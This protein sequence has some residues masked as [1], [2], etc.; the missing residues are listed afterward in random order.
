MDR[1][2]LLAKAAAARAARAESSKV[3]AGSRAVAVIVYRFVR[4]ASARSRLSK[5]K[6]SG[7]AAK[8][9][10]LGKVAALLQVKGLPFVPPPPA[11][12]LLLRDLAQ[13]DVALP[14]DFASGAGSLFCQLVSWMRRS[15]LTGTALLQAKGGEGVLLRLLTRIM[16]RALLHPALPATDKLAFIDV[17]ALS[18]G[19]P[20]LSTN[21]QALHAVR[22]GEASTP[23]QLR[24][25][26]TLL[27]TFATAVARPLAFA[28]SGPGDAATRVAS[29][30]VDLSFALAQ[31]TPR[32]VAGRSPL[33]ELS[34]AVG[35][36][37]TIPW[38]ITR[39]CGAASLARPAMI[40][41]L[42]SVAIAFPPTLLPA[43]ECG[44]VPNP[45]PWKRGRGAARVR[46][47][48]ADTAL[49]ADA[50]LAGGGFMPSMGVR[51][52]FDVEKGSPASPKSPTSFFSSALA[53]ESLSRTTA[54]EMGAES[55]RVRA[56]LAAWPAQAYL[57]GNLLQLLADA[58]P[59]T[60]SRSEYD[61]EEAEVVGRVLAGGAWPALAFLPPSGA[62][63]ALTLLADLFGSIPPEAFT[64]TTPMI[65]PSLSASPV[66]MPPQLASQLRR[67]SSERLARAAAAL[68][69]RRTGPLTNA[70]LLL[71]DDP[72]RRDYEDTGEEVYGVGTGA[73]APR[74]GAAGSD[75]LARAASGWSL[76]ARSAAWA[77]SK[78]AQGL[79]R[80]RGG[81]AERPPVP[82]SDAF[83]SASPAGRRGVEATGRPSFEDEHVLAFCCLYAELVSPRPLAAGAAEASDPILNRGAVLQS[84]SFHP[85]LAT[86]HLLWLF[87]A[88]RLG[89][90]SWLSLAG[91][92]ATCA[93][94]G[95]WGVLTVF[96]AVMSCATLVVDDLELYG[97]RSGETG[98]LALLPPLPE[99]RHS[100]RLLR[101][102]L[103]HGEGIG[104]DS[105]IIAN[106]GAHLAAAPSPFWPRFASM[107]T[108]ALRALYERHCQRP[109]GP[110]SMWVL[111]PSTVELTIVRSGAP[112]EASGSDRD[113][114][115][116][117]LLSRL[118]SSVPFADRLRVYNRVREADRTVAQVG[119]PQ[120]R[121]VVH[122]SRLFESAYSALRDVR[123]PAWKRKLYVEFVNAEGAR[124]AG[125]DAGGPFK[126]L[127][128]SLAEYIFSPSY[129]LWAVTEGGDLYPNP[130]AAALSG[131][132]VREAFAFL[133]RVTGKA[134]YEGITVGPRWAR[135]WLA[136]VLGRQSTL[137]D[138]P[139]LDPELY[140]SLMFLRTCAAE[141]VPDLCLSFVAAAD[142]AAGEKEV[143]LVKGGGDVSVTA[144][145]RLA[146][147]HAVARH[148]LRASIVVHTEAF[149]AGLYEVLPGSWLSGFSPP[150]L[151]VLASGSEAGIDV[152]D[153]KAST[154]YAG[155]YSGFDRVVK[156]FWSVVEAMSQRDR[157]ALLRFATAAERPPPLGFSRLEPQFTIARVGSAGNPEGLLPTSSTC[158][159]ILKLPHYSKREELKAKLLMAIH[160]GTGFELT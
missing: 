145:N 13:A 92:K 134:L 128:T 41:T 53:Q 88:D 74:G 115:I 49:P 35:A 27:T 44:T 87:I 94:T 77:T 5:A 69:L 11:L 122:R 160:S 1:G 2:S 146:Y 132:D 111:D 129:G 70:R 138:L 112:E 89:M 91:Y 114:A 19:L 68:L 46:S 57:L 139:S 37:L 30:A 113:V 22:M 29:L 117:R 101:D 64:A 62:S 135:F 40:D 102:V 81:T 65:W 9:G 25:H 157:A 97:T 84:L 3:Q 31:S 54:A 12:L 14:L 108:A 4:G 105:Y 98:G 28:V 59:V 119:Q 58:P 130:A 106:A 104:V 96:A 75:N 140:R 159:H 141:D 100:V 150:E 147:I 26:A 7:L 151:Q 86:P 10:D 143:E 95:T 154:H 73:G 152:T 20:A 51:S 72:E 17:L 55:A 47:T 120:V 76:V 155:G 79:F 131:L 144:S 71:S 24:V 110:L 38:L 83:V 126:E 142:E 8:L 15:L 48:A 33:L 116:A 6:T 127:W 50:L 109:L 43:N 121:I 56:Q 39:G 156:D 153:W 124:E 60:P 67:F 93:P 16:P 133:G 136:Q 36:L 80:K 32:D 61:A 118:P 148:R 125:I 82:A 45:K 158:F 42:I 85:L 34:K 149:R 107:A 18:A 103:L 21:L 66:P 137:H 78:L 23:L 90:K 99:L 52:I 123:G 63:R